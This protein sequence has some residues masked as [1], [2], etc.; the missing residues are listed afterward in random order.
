MRKS[1]KAYIFFIVIFLS[2]F[3]PIF[4]QKLKRKNS[5][6]SRQNSQSTFVNF[7]PDTIFALLVAEK[8][9]KKIADNVTIKELA[10]I[11]GYF[12]VGP[13]EV[14]NLKGIG[15]LINIDSFNCYKNGVVELPDEFY[16]LINL[17]SLDLCKSGVDISN[18]IGKLK[19]LTY[20]RFNL[21]GIN[22]IPNTIGNLTQLETLWICCNQI[23]EIPKEIGQLRKLKDLDLHSNDI[24][25]LPDEICNLK[26]LKRLD[27][28]YCRVRK[29]PEN[30][31]NLK[32]L[33]SLNLFGNNLKE[34][35]KSIINLNK[36][37]SLNVFDNFKLN[38][39][40]KKYLPK[41]LR[42]KK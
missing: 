32:N 22:K 36:L 6:Q 29:L 37:S 39:N 20:I 16:N 11:K 30:I 19:N 13:G 9:N 18:K 4:A 42:K 33:T 21:S 1:S 28:S 27:I 2:T 5:F 38:E 31:G 17:K 34:L 26:S 15:F 41:K 8:L 7:F 23:K 10:S 3:I 24:S 12:E 35:P 25:T 14:S 40:Y